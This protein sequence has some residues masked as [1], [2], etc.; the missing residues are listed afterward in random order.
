M[1]VEFDKFVPLKGTDKVSISL[2]A[3]RKDIQELVGMMMCGKAQ[4]SMPEMQTADE[5]T[6]AQHLI[7]LLQP[8]IEQF[9]EE[10]TVK[11]EVNGSLIDTD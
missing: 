5:E 10:Q 3:T 8:V 4:L 1:K 7:R 6:R 9:M 2:T 11:G